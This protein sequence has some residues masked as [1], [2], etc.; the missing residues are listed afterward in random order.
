MDGGRPGRFLIGFLTFAGGFVFSALIA[1]FTH[2]FAGQLHG[3]DF[4]SV[5]IVGVSFLAVCLTLLYLVAQVNELKSD[6]R[7]TIRYF[8]RET[9]LEPGAT[10]E[11]MPGRQH[12]S[13]AGLAAHHAVVGFGCSL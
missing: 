11:L 6:Y 9:G 13:E 8:D 5:T 3:W 10:A 12:G 1:H 4:W 7:L 2:F